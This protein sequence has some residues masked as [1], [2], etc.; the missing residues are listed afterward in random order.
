MI[1]GTTIDDSLLKTGFTDG[2]KLGLDD[3]YTAYLWNYCSGNVTD[4]NW[5]ITE[6][7]KPKTSFYFNVYEIFKLDSDA[8]GKAGLTENDIPSSVQKVD[9]A[10]KAVSNVMVALYCLGLVSLA[11]TFIVGWFG[12]LSRWGSCVTTIFAGVGSSGP[13]LML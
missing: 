12:L 4:G 2:E 7:A 10:I 9:K 1:P 13:R 5:K 6:C 11:V 3:F 8:N